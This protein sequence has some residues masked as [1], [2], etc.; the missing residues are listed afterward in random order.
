MV[1]RVL[2]IVELLSRRS[3]IH[4]LFALYGHH[5]TDLFSALVKLA[6]EHENLETIQHL[7]FPACRIH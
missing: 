3:V 7:L 1:P 5:T 4:S 2:Q 6:G